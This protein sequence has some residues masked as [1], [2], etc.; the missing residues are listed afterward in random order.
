MWPIYAAIGAIV[1]FWATEE[2]PEPRAVPKRLSGPGELQS[3]EQSA[4]AVPS[5]EPLEPESSPATPSQ[6]EPAS[7]PSDQAPTSASSKS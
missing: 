7:R 1:L 3:D 5:I 6:L 4:P 2:N